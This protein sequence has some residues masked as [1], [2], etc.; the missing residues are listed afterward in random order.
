MAGRRGTASK[1][2][3]K[4]RTSPITFCWRSGDIEADVYSPLWPARALKAL[5]SPPIVVK[6]VKS[7]SGVSNV[8]GVM[9]A[10]VGG[11]LVSPSFVS[12]TE[13]WTDCGMFLP[14]HLVSP[15]LKRVS[16]RLVSSSLDKVLRSL[17]S[18]SCYDMFASALWCHGFGWPPLYL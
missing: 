10:L 7:T 5:D 13:S 4:C 17:G 14:R 15:Q 18:S 1:A 9:N 6:D 12:S 11:M 2:I 3:S 8:L 16:V